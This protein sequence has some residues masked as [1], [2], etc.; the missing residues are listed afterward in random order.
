M[1]FLCPKHKT[2]VV[3]SEIAAADLWHGAML[4]GERAF[5]RCQ[6]ERARAFFGSAFEI[7]KIRLVAEPCS[8]QARVT[9]QHLAQAS[10][11]LV[12]TLYLVDDFR[13]AEQC[14]LEQHYL[15][16]FFGVDERQ[17]HHWQQQALNLLDQQQ[18]NLLRLLK[19]HQQ[20]AKASA[21]QLL[22]QKLR[23]QAVVH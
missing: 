5:N 8:E 14:L 18:H 2:A 6:L 20:F 22:T 13:S 10:Q 16:L 17:I 23:S 15:L 4:N 21:L 3:N 7:A 9:P 19:R 12:N 11:R 1:S